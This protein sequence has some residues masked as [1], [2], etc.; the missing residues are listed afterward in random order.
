ME[1]NYFA[2]LRLIQLT[3]PSMRER[4]GGCIVNVSSVAGRVATVCQGGYCASK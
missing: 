4:G 1:T 3:L 2:I